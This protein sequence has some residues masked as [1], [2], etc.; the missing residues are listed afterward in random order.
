[1]ALIYLQVTGNELPASL[2][3]EQAKELI[4]VAMR[5]R[6]VLV[7]LDDVWEPAHESALSCFIDTST[8][9]KVLITT[10]IKG[11]GVAS[12]LELGLPSP[13]DS[14]KLLLASA[15]LAHL[16][17]APAEATE[18]VGIMGCL[19]L[20]VD[21]AGRMLQDLGVDSSDWTGIP[22]LLQ[23]EMRSSGDSDETSVEYRVIA[24]SL[25]AIPLRDRANAKRLFSVFAVVAEDTHVPMM[26]LRILLSAVTGDA[27][28]VPELPS[29]GAF[30]ATAAAAAAGAATPVAT[31]AAT[32]AAGCRR[33]HHHHR[34]R[35]RRHR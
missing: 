28:L 10:R 21:L 7:V 13:A 12:Q 18:I 27:V 35:R 34:R 25:N 15:G 33:R 4:T 5:D 29:S 23:D 11:L 30:A 22:K 8:S 16:S 9:S 17:P 6:S 31:V 1:M 20:A 2:G 3:P 24:A 14:V 32:T 26:A 19:P